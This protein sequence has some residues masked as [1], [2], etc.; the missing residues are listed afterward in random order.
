[1]HAGSL[2]TFFVWGG[3]V[4]CQSILIAQTSTLS[5][6]TDSLLGFIFAA[7]V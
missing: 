3:E 2:R 4:K 6:G 7:I 5:V 1:M